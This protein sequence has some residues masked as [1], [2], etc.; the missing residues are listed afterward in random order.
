MAYGAFLIRRRDLPDLKAGGGLPQGVREH[1]QLIGGRYD[2]ADRRVVAFRH[3]GNVFDTSGN[4]VVGV[5]LLTQRSGNSVDCRENLVGAAMD[6]RHG[7]P[8]MSDK[9]HAVID[10]HGSL[11]HAA[12]RLH[13]AVAE[14][15]RSYSLS[16]VC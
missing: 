4:F 12:Y 13:R 11:R 1:L 16:E 5:A 3:L 8:G 7:I 2:V 9:L 6:G 15:S 14:P 10:H